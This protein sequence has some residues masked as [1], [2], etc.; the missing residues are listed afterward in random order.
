MPLLPRV[1][2]P[3][4]D[5]LGLTPV[6]RLD[7][8]TELTAAMNGESAERF[9]TSRFLLATALAN[10]P[11]AL[12]KV[13]SSHVARVLISGGSYS[14]NLDWSDL[15]RLLTHVER[16]VPLL[17]AAVAEVDRC[18]SNT[19][20][21]VVA[22]LA[23]GDPE[24]WST[25][26]LTDFVRYYSDELIAIIV[27]R[28]S[29]GFERARVFELI[30]RAAALTHALDS[31]LVRAAVAGYV[32]DRTALYKLVG[33]DRTR[34]VLPFLTSRTT[35]E[36]LGAAEWLKAHPTNEAI[37]GLRTAAR[38]ESDDRA[39]TTMLSALE[40]LDQPLDEFVGPDTLLADAT[41]AL[42]KSSTVPKALRWLSLESLP[43]LTW[44]DGRPVEPAIVQ[45]FLTSAVKNKSAEPSPILRR[46][47]ANMDRAQVE[48]FG[49]TL[50]DLWLNEDQRP[51]T[52]H[53]ARAEARKSAAHHFRWQQSTPSGATKTL[54]QIEDEL[55][56]HYR[57]T[58]TTSATA[59]K[60][61][62]A[63]VAASASADVTERTMAYIRRHR[64]HR[65]SQG[66]SLL[67]MLAWI[68]Q[69]AT[70]QAVMS[71]A[72]RFRPKGMQNEA[73][74]QAELLAERHGWTLDDLADR[75]V[76]AGGFESDGR[77]TISYDARTF[78][79]HLGDD[80]SVTLV[81][82]ET[83]KTLKSLPPGRSGEDAE[84][85]KQAKADLAAAKKDLKA[86][87]ALQPDRLHLAMSV[88]RRWS[89]DD[90]ERYF[91]R[92]PVMV[93]L[94]T[95]L[96]WVATTPDDVIGFRPLTDG[97][98]IT[99]DDGDLARSGLGDHHRPRTAPS[100]DLS[101]RWRQHIADYEVTPCSP[102][103]GVLN[104]TSS[105]NSWRSPISSDSC[106]TTGH[107]VA[108]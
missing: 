7:L 44:T 58:M 73:L 77:Q 6:G 89:S 32:A 27:T 55:T 21:G 40:I 18:D 50:L 74:L 46:H 45:W 75:S 57:Q 80:L 34:D 22:H 3:H 2:L 11:R 17:L 96:I 19:V 49:A 24:L 107:F 78:T 62:L 64:G 47:F 90:F 13:T 9:T 48:R 59:S 95:R 43:A 42:A 83:G 31:S 81:N 84:N 16:P 97:S 5:L 51:V 98:L 108:R 68:D 26:E 63:V 85:I 60:G 101:S 105:P 76:P 41:R 33:P 8:A 65:M 37:E 70:V 25:Q 61:L 54:Q 87:L 53:E 14:F 72:T 71:V 28:P 10:E 106:T 93:R 94:A 88:Q 82:D 1:E 23:H 67:Q 38:V 52:E 4:L 20:I 99:I 56:A 86:V 92:H 36:R 103:S 100:R 15:A 29:W 66:K 12:R 69:P 35:S 102:S 91:V 39:K 104:S 30:G 79:A